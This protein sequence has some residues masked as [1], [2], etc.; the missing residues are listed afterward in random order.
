MPVT[1]EQVAPLRAQ[2]TGHLDEH[3]RLIAQLDDSALNN[4]Y[5]RLVT[6]AFCIAAERRFP[7][8]ATASDVIQF[9]GDFRARTERTEE[10][11]PRMAERIIRTVISDEDTEDINPRTSWEIQVLLLAAM[12]TDARYD[13]A[14]LEEFL[15]EARKLAD[16]WMS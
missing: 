2:L 16:Q 4:G 10:I 14:G 15:G 11:D 12:T 8:G 5:R 3:R 7:P 13:A 1:D 6:A 9:V